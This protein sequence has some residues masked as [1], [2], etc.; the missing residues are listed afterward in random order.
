VLSELGVPVNH[1]DRRKASIS[2]VRPYHAG[3]GIAASTTPS[4]AHCSLTH[5]LSLTQPPIPAHLTQ[6]PPHIS[7]FISL[8]HP[9]S[10]SFLTPPHSSLLTLHSAFTH[11]ARTH[12]LPNTNLLSS[13]LSLHISHTPPLQAK[14]PSLHSILHLILQS[15]MSIISSP[16]ISSHILASRLVSSRPVSSRLTL[17]RLS[18]TL[19]IHSPPAIRHLPS[20]ISRV[21]HL[22]RAGQPPGQRGQHSRSGSRGSGGSPGQ[23]CLCN[24]GRGRGRPGYPA[25]PQRCPGPAPAV[26]AAGALPPVS[27]F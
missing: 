16:L 15:S 19:I 17:L 4:S 10:F 6:D 22:P 9:H 2:H 18:H 26:A 24:R 13:H 8:P 7:Q 5:S 25:P 27:T 11:P 23:H 1:A 21:D 12:T 3:A 20:P 14:L